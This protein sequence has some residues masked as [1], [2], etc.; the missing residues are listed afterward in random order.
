MIAS[1]IGVYSVPLLRRIRPQLHK[2]SMTCVIANCTTVLV[3]SS[4]LPV[5]AR[6]L[7]ITTFD[8]VGAY[9]SF[10]WLSNFT[11]V[12]TYNVA[13]AIAT[14]FCLF[15][16]FTAPVRREI[17]QR[18]V[19]AQLFLACSVPLYTDSQCGHLNRSFY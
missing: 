2:T 5:L 17:I 16:Y 6:T 15:N 8:L 14:V 7:G 18:Y 4:A 1:V 12:W 3:L 19:K 9:S 11:L 10:I 13:F